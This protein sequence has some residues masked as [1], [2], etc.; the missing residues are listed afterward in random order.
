MKNLPNS[1]K[2]KSDPS[3]EV[4]PG[5]EVSA[6]R[7]FSLR[8]L[9]ML[10]LLFF[11]AA[12][13]LAYLYRATLW[14]YTLHYYQYVS[15][16]EKI[17]DLLT[18]SG[19]WAP[20]IFVSFQILQVIFAPIPGEATG[21]LGGF[22]FGVPLG[23]LYSTI[24][25]TVGS[26]L[27]FLLGRWLEI[28]FVARV[29]DPETMKKFDFLMERQGA[30]ISFLFFLIPGFPKDYLCFILGVSPMHL[31]IFLLI[32]TIGRLPGTLLLTLQGAKVYEGNYL[33]FG[34]LLGAI[35]VGGLVLWYY[36]EGLYRWLKHWGRCKYDGDPR[37]QK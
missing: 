1:S 10:G 14:E 25:L 13:V 3:T 24:G 16:K 30:L 26:I 9:L 12:A 5:A 33:D 32:C 27:A 20:L 31:R 19:S 4:L 17:K 2:L 22:L 18:A 8:G 28:H 23:F 36:R 11:L 35:L 6:P 34:I 37:G 29:V 21:F 7:R 15:T